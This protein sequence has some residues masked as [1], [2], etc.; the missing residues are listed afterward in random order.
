MQQ[1]GKVQEGNVV[2]PRSRRAGAGRQRE[3]GCREKPK[4]CL[5]ARF[6]PQKKTRGGTFAAP[7]RMERQAAFLTLVMD[8]ASGFGSF[9][10]F[11]LAANSCFTF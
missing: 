11:A 5:S 1:R 9:F 6:S 3:C 10:A 7:R 4:R 8:L 2:L